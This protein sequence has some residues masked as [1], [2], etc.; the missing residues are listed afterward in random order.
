MRLP[1][2][3][4]LAGEL[5]ISPATVAAA[6]RTLKQRGL[7]KAEGRRGT[8]VAGEPPLRVGASAPVPAHARDLARGNP[9]PA[10]LPSLAGALA[11]VGPDHRLYGDEAKYAPLVDHAR[12]LFD[13]DGIHGEIAVLGGAL[14]GVE[15]AL[16]SRLRPG[17][18]VIVEDPTWPRTTDL[19]HA[20]G[21]VTVPV[22]V[23]DEGFVPA[24]L[25]RALRN[26][27]A[28]VAS[29]RAQNPVGAA[30][31]PARGRRL[32]ELLGGHPDVLV[33]EDDYAWA[34]AGAPY[35]P[36]HRTTRRWV[37]VRSLSKILAPDLRVALVAGDSLTV[38][39]IEG[40]QLLGPGWV[41]HVLQQ[42]AT[43][44]LS[45]SATRALLARAERTYAKR[46]KALIDALAVHGIEAHGRSGLSVWIPVAEEATTTQL[47]LERGWA[48]S[49]GE[50]YRFDSPPGIRVTVATLEP[51]EAMRLAAAIAETSRGGSQTYAA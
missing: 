28:V 22:A 13:A 26:A 42:V 30:L 7:V 1:P 10:L 6:Y 2:V 23:D 5:E 33:V 15:R 17:D 4:E 46:R 11:H 3:R 49:P 19:V 29:P 31:T 43:R 48:V 44:L 38:S 36:L 47:L 37:V 32:R 51:A 41:S 20:L 24:A 16:Q 21:Y 45:S 34:V 9:D 50:R 39:R 35:V 8:T 18:H 14:D 40:R 25:E 27:R 12:R